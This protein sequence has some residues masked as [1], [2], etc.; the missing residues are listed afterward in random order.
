MTYAHPKCVWQSSQTATMLEQTP[1][2]D[3]IH[4]P[5][6]CSAETLLLEVFQRK[7][8]SLIGLARRAE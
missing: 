1:C 5:M 2:Y 3:P 7:R 6:R 4:K 8:I